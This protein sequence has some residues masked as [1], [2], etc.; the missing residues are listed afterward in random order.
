MPGGGGFPPSTV[1]PISRVVG[2][3]LNGLSKANIA[4]IAPENRPFKKERKVVSKPN[5][6]SGARLMLVFRGEV[7]FLFVEVLSLDAQ[8]DV[9]CC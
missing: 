2:P 5:Q 9:M 1:C 6:F 4:A 3:L 7:C 8:K